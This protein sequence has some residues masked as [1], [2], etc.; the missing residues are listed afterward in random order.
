MDYVRTLFSKTGVVIAAY[1][2]IGVFVNTTAPHLP[3]GQDLSSLHSWAQYLISVFF[4]PLSLW[5]PVFTTG[6]WHP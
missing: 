5:H 1:V 2:L 4:W 3:T 6:R